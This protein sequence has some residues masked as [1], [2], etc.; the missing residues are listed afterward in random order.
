MSSYSSRSPQ[1]RSSGLHGN[2]ALAVRVGR[3]RLLRPRGWPSWLHAHGDDGCHSIEIAYHV[4]QGDTRITGER[5]AY[6][7]HFYGLQLLVPFWSGRGVGVFVRPAWCRPVMSPDD[8][9]SCV[10]AGCHHT[11]CRRSS[12]P[13]PGVLWHDCVGAERDHS[14]RLTEGGRRSLA[15]A[16]FRDQ[17]PYRL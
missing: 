12:H 11:G 2:C 4:V 1:E 16:T 17:L 10:V 6:D 15:A 13:D 5:W 8:C 14:R 3:G 9:R 7:F